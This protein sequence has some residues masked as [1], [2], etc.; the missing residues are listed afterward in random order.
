[1][2]KIY[3]IF[4]ALALLTNVKANT[5][6]EINTGINLHFG[7]DGTENI[8]PYINPIVKYT[9]NRTVHDYV[10]TD[11]INSSSNNTNN[12]NN[13]NTPPSNNEVY[14]PYLSNKEILLF[15]IREYVVDNIHTKYYTDFKIKN[16]K[17]GLSAYG[18]VNGNDVFGQDYNNINIGLKFEKNYLKANV[19]YHLSKN[20]KNYNKLD[21]FY[22]EEQFDNKDISYSLDISPFYY[23]KF[24][25]SLH[26]IGKNKN[27]NISPTI[28]FNNSNLFVSASVNFNTGEDIFDIAKDIDKFN[29]TAPGETKIEY[30]KTWSLKENVAPITDKE[31]FLNENP[32]FINA[33]VSGYKGTHRL[34][35]LPSGSLYGESL[36][37]F[38]LRTTIN[39]IKNS[40]DFPTL[41]SALNKSDGK[42]SLTW[43]D[44]ITLLPTIKS[45]ISEV[46]NKNNINKLLAKTTKDIL[47]KF[48]LDED[49]TNRSNTY[50]TKVVPSELKNLLPY[51]NTLF[52]I[53]ND[54]NKFN[55]IHLYYGYNDDKLSNAKPNIDNNVDNNNN[56]DS[57][58]S[59][60]NSSTNNN[61]KYELKEINSSFSNDISNYT[62]EMLKYTYL[63]EN[64]IN[65]FD[66][67]NNL[68]F[69]NKFS[70]I[71]NS[72]SDI[73]KL[74]GERA[75]YTN[76]LKWPDEIKGMELL[77]PFYFHY[78]EKQ[79][80]EKKLKK[81]VDLWKEEINAVVD[82]KQKVYPSITL[83]IAY[84][85]D[86]LNANLQLNLLKKLNINGEN[87]NFDRKTNNI[88]LNVNY[89]VKKGLKFNNI[90]DFLFANNKLKTENLDINYNDINIKLKNYLGYNFEI[91]NKWLL[92]LGLTHLGEYGKITPNKVYK[93]DNEFTIEATKR[94]ENNNPI[95]L[96]GNSI[97]T[98][99]T[100]EK[101]II[102]K[103][104]DMNIA[105]V[106][107]DTMASDFLQKENK[108][109][110]SAWYTVYNILAP[111]IA[112]TF[113]PI[114][115]FEL[116]N[117]LEFPLAFEYK[118]FSGVNILYKANIK[119]LVNNLD[120][121][122]FKDKLNLYGIKTNGKLEVGYSNK[123]NFYTKYTA[124]L[125]TPFLDI[126]V[127]S[128]KIIPNYNAKFNLFIVNFPLRPAVIFE[129]DNNN[130]Y[131]KYGLELNKNNLSVVLGISKRQKDKL[132]LY[133]DVH[134]FLKLRENYI[135][136]QE[137]EKHKNKFEN[138]DMLYNYSHFAQAKYKKNDMNIEFSLNTS[139]SNFST[140][141]IT[142]NKTEDELDYKINDETIK[143][144]GDYRNTVNWSS[145]SRAYKY[146]NIVSVKALDNIITTVEKKE[147]IFTNYNIK[148]KLEKEKDTGLNFKTSM[149]VDYTNHKSKFEIGELETKYTKNKIYG[150]II[151]K[152]W[153][154]VGPKYIDIKNEFTDDKI[155]SVENVSTETSTKARLQELGA[156]LT[157]A[158]RKSDTEKVIDAVIKGDIPTKEVID[159]TK[160]YTLEY[161][162]FLIDLNNKLSYV[163]KYKNLKTKLNLNH[164]LQV[165]YEKV[166]DIQLDDIKLYSGYNLDII[167]YIKPELE[168]SYNI[169]N[170]IKLNLSNSLEFKFNKTK[171]QETKYIFNTSI[172]YEW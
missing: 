133:N 51:Y 6:I 49:T 114:E 146:L 108:S 42:E 129:K 54:I 30:F 33:K 55:L 80:N 134:N 159:N 71:M 48:Q 12:N 18:I 112:L 93:N 167:N 9:K 83:N 25:P 3:I 89:G 168:F 128:K 15:K 39:N 126:N 149:L 152:N 23:K 111:K 96:D 61:P 97:I 90:T 43:W 143:E 164:R 34:V 98:S 65:N 145:T 27:A 81:E 28:N 119:Y 170:K 62:L 41:T 172:K 77:N 141:N 123:D 29:F 110:V 105:T 36:T 66:N 5:E 37:K 121:D 60:N 78:T 10:R 151:T 136:A 100:T 87:F 21:K 157:F 40:G 155:I 103:L 113:K 85:K 122:I 46:E 64:I 4:F 137:F 2:K 32:D 139:K 19:V 92:E 138:I 26:I 104:L 171:Y 13:T 35:G 125:I 156:R 154:L 99:E 135:D 44:T 79:I 17:L 120:F 95:G 75:K 59:N 142:T 63:P 22:E 107:R 162:K 53:S 31:S 82:K 69:F 24:S 109:L 127:N 52:D 147:N 68:G 94:D 45:I 84:K 160:K 50:F 101:Q 70:T 166:S 73:F 76:A 165:K 20:K 118:S 57:N 115:N 8:L 161:T 163:F 144:A 67:F 1:M 131:I 106:A 74:Y 14:V 158:W 130:Q 153:L 47:D 169:T 38:L 58:S 88:I 116:Y 91:N 56:S 148:F 11:N 132:N 124:N 16:S 117:S 140:S 150:V 7:I 72:L 102:D 86:K